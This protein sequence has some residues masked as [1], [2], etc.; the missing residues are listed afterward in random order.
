MCS[1]PMLHTASKL[2]SQKL[3]GSAVY[4]GFS[5]KSTKFK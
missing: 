5:L 2:E 1:Q 4:S 3:P